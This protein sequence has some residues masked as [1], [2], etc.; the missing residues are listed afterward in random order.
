MLL[1]PAFPEERERW[2]AKQA[3][4]ELEAQADQADQFTARAFADLV[5]SPHPK[6]R[7]PQGSAESLARLKPADCSAFH[8]AALERGGF[9]VVT[10]EIDVDAV[11]AAAERLFVALPAPTPPG[12]E[13]PSAPAPSARRREI[14]TRASDQA[15][16]FVGQ[17]S[18]AR[19]DPEFEA[20][21]LAGVILG[22]GAGLTGRIPQ[23][24]RERE[25]LAYYASAETV[26]AAGLDPGRLV[27]YAGTD[28]E[29]LA[30]AELAM[31][32]EISRLVGDGITEVELEEA[33]AYLVG[34][35]PFRRETARQW[36]DA[37][38]QSE[39]VGLPLDDPERRLAR[40]AAV[41]RAA[42]ESA[43]RRHFDP[44]RLAVAI[45]LPRG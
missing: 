30:Q 32:E 36:S 28:P 2:I 15:H 38:V 23:R 1:E 22:A 16:L 19:A 45:G 33:R 34:R 41:N 26:A 24:I 18:V 14:V 9:V 13:P 42:V 4:G 31:R 43:L 25:G 12:P 11:A 5:H 27:A 3:A 35:D 37:M 8:A 40:L 6:G 29:Q 21:E 44:E 39:I 7:A 10:G 17:L 20:L